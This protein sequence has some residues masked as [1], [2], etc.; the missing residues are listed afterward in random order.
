MRDDAAA[1]LADDPLTALCVLYWNVT[2]G[3][4][5]FLPDPAILRRAKRAMDAALGP[6]T[7]EQR[8]NA[9]VYAA[10]EDSEADE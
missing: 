1:R 6:L 3:S 9:A 2:D 8:D 10:I 5:R 4:A 7:K